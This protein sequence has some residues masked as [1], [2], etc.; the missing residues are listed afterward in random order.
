[1]RVYQL[2]PSLFSQ[3]MRFRPKIWW[4]SFDFQNDTVDF[5]FDNSEG[6][7]FFSCARNVTFVYAC[8][9]QHPPPPF[10]VQIVDLH[11][12]A[13]I[14][15]VH[16]RWR[17]KHYLRF[18]FCA[19]EASPLVREA[20]TRACRTKGEGNTRGCAFGASKIFPF[21]FA[22]HS[23]SVSPKGKAKRW[24]RQPFGSR[25]DA[26]KRHNRRVTADL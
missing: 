11:V 19:P 7:F 23:P 1:M 9:R 22:K 12:N 21:E 20:M 18:T 17:W 13:S 5:V 4:P 24:Q 15:F 6:V 14:R 16:L 25:S 2:T 8:F 26:K 10:G 3:I